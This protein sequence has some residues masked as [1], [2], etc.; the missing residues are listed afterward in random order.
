M[1]GGV[2]AVACFSMSVQIGIN[3]LR[4]GRSFLAAGEFPLLIS[5]SLFSYAVAYEHIYLPDGGL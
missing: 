2:V 4:V 5:S 1:Y 3:T